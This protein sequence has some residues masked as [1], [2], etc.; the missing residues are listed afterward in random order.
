MSREFVDLQIPWKDTDQRGASHCVGKHHHRQGIHCS[1][2]LTEEQLLTQAL[3]WKRERPRRTTATAQKK[4]ETCESLTSSKKEQ[5]KAT[6]KPEGVEAGK[7]P[8]YTSG[9]GG[10]GANRGEKSS[11]QRGNGKNG[12]RGTERWRG[13][14][15]HV[16]RQDLQP[17]VL[18][19]ATRTCLKLVKKSRVVS[20]EESEHE[21]W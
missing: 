7:T 16:A 17:R 8:R 21:R 18:K 2:Q 1:D 20:V 11:W 12:G 3:H 6:G 10:K 15:G 14:A 19:A 13:H 4:K 9:T 5:A